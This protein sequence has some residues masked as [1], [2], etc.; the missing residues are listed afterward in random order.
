[1]A[2]ADLALPG[3]SGKKEEENQDKISEKFLIKTHFV[4]QAAGYNEAQRRLVS[5]GNPATVAC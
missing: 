3:Q 4:L 5:P 2:G 1:L